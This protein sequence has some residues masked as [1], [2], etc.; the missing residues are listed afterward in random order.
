MGVVSEYARRKGAQS[1]TNI[2]A[3]NGRRAQVI[4]ARNLTKPFRA[5]GALF[6][7]G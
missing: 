1:F 4:L 6:L 2:A 5:A 7:F 3:C